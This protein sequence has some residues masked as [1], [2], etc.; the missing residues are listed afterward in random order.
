MQG[1][2]SICH[3]GNLVNAD[4]LKQ[5]LEEQGSIFSS[6]SDTEVLG[7]LIKRQSGHMI[8]RICTSLDKL[9]GA[10]AFLIRL[11]IE[12]ML[13]G[14]NMDYDLYQ[15]GNFTKWCLCVCI[16][17]MRIRCRWSKICKRC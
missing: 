1:S 15:L 6:T 7:H 13:Q 10:F 9:D 11:I 16:R 4:I 14:T 12:F 5:E 3:N 8:D 17:N 2:M